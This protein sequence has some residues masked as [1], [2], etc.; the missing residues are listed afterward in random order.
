MYKKDKLLKLQE[1]KNKILTK[2]NFLL[3]DLQEVSDAEIRNSTNVL[4]EK[5][6]LQLKKIDEK[7]EK[8]RLN[9]PEGDI[10]E[11]STAI[12]NE[13]PEQNIENEEVQ[14][15]ETVEV[16]EEASIENLG[17]YQNFEDLE[18]FED[19]ERKEDF[20]LEEELNRIKQ[21]YDI[22]NSTY[23]EPAQEEENKEEPEQVEEPVQDDVQNSEPEQVEEVEQDTIQNE[24]PEQVEEVEQDTVQNE[25]PEQVEEVEQD[26]VQNE[27][28]EQV[29]EVEQDTVQYSEPEQIEETEEYDIDEE[30]KKLGQKYDVEVKEQPLEFVD[31]DSS[32]TDS[33]KV[34]IGRKDNGDI[35]AMY[36]KKK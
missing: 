29:E 12:E 28:P 9:G 34:Y 36:N 17:N 25:E 18:D 4:L 20:D 3:E 16:E 22:S 31:Y 1:D 35:L 15:D 8:E 26:T 33:P 14:Q 24:E 7:L 10:A 32:D 19:F 30:L 5:L 6:R 13:E 27:E 21:K 2:M 11:E 23:Q